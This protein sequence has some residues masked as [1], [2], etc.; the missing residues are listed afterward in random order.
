[1]IDSANF[2]EGLC[3]SLPHL[4]FVFLCVFWL[5]WGSWLTCYVALEIDFAIDSMYLAHILLCSHFEFSFDVLG[6]WLIYCLSEQITNNHAKWSLLCICLHSCLFQ[7]CLYFV[8]YCQVLMERTALCAQDITKICFDV[9][10]MHVH[11]KAWHL[12]LIY[13]HGEIGWGSTRHSN[14]PNCMINIR[15]FLKGSSRGIDIIYPMFIS[16]LVNHAKPK[17]LVSPPWLVE[18]IYFAQF[19]VIFWKLITLQLLPFFLGIQKPG[20]AYWW[21][22]ASSGD[23]SCIAPLLHWQ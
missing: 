11:T 2:L 10:R 21:L 13:I 14:N 22:L 8:Y 16:S 4:N 9:I 19:A 15:M 1:M 23:S 12:T 18:D 3:F 20:N 7:Y 5:V 17:T 6:K